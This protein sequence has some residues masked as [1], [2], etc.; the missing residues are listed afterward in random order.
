M[1]ISGIVAAARQMHEAIL[2]DTGTIRRDGP[3]TLNETTGLYTQTPTTVYAGI[4]KVVIPK[5]FPNSSAAVGQVLVEVHARLDLPVIASAAVRDGDVLTLDTSGDPALVGR[6]F[7][8]SGFAGQSQTS[9]R[10]FW[11]E[12]FS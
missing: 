3:K 4:C 1:D 7:K 2:P 6:K 11:L 12:G 5:Q 9:V 10:R 8:L